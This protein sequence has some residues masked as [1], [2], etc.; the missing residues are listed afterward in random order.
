MSGKVWFI[1]GCS[2]GIGRTLAEVL[3]A[4]SG[5]RVACTSRSLQ[6]IADVA[7]ANDQ[8]FL[9]LEV[10]LASEASVQLAITSATA[11]FGTIDVLVNNAG[12][13]QVG[14][15]ED[16]SDEELK[17][18]YEIN[19]FAPLRV[20]RLVAPLMRAQKSGYI[21]NVS[22]MGALVSYQCFSSYC[23]TKSA[24]NMATEALAS[25]LKPFGVK[26]LS[27]NPGCFKTDFFSANK[28]QVPS[29][30]NDSVYNEQYQKTFFE[31]TKNL[32]ALLIGDPTKL[33]NL[34]IEVVEHQGDLPVHIYV[35]TDAHALVRA[36]AE[37][38]L[39]DLDTWAPRTNF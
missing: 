17:K 4:T 2:S 1:T 37:Q 30:I 15:V 32:D 20:I 18:N 29:N 22:S 11:K 3:L 33:A 39:K 16:L 26:A 12:Y 6:S 34:F 27:I 25:E 13:G 36:K 23:S 5:A 24:L 21:I 7:G 8:N 9:A 14:A 38:I 31:P 35:G 19:F 10:D 28:I